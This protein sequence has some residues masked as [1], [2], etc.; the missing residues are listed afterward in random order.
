[1]DDITVGDRQETHPEKKHNMSKAGAVESR[2]SWLVEVDVYLEDADSDPPQFRL[3][4][5]LPMDPEDPD[6][7]ITFHN[8][9]RPGFD[10]KFNL[11]DETGQGYSFPP[12]GK[13]DEALWSRQ[14]PGCPPD[15]HNQ[16]WDQFTSV[17]VIEP[18]QMTLVVHNKNETIT[19]FGYTLRVTKDNGVNYIDLDPGGNNQNGSD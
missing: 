4:T 16:Q 2:P 18:D 19:E 14:G 12:Q 9:G 1:M 7:V 6:K 10:I 5:C 17:R 11:I 8:R 15:N 3:E 13:R